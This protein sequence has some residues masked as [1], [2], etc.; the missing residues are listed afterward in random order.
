MEDLFPSKLH[1]FP[2]Q[3]KGIQIAVWGLV[4]TL[5][6][7]CDQA[8]EKYR[9]DEGEPLQPE[10]TV[11]LIRESLEQSLKYLESVE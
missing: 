8:L 11:E 9:A 5:Y 10:R 6:S 1:K 4:D 7:M 2:F 3:W